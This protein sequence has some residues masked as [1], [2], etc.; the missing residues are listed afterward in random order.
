M[1]PIRQWFVC[2]TISLSS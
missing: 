1:F 2:H